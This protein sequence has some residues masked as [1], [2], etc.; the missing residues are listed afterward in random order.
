TVCK[1]S[2]SHPATAELIHIYG[3]SEGTFLA[4]QR[5]IC[6]IKPGGGYIPQAAQF[7]ALL[8]DTGKELEGPNVEGVLVF[9]RPWC[10]VVAGFWGDEEA[11]EAYWK[12]YWEHEPYSGYFYSGDV[13]RRDEDGLYTVIG[14]VDDVIKT[15]YA[16][17]IGTGEVESC[18]SMHPA[19]AEV[20]AVGC[21]H[22]IMGR[23]L[24]LFVRLFPQVSAKVT[25]AML[26]K[27]KKDFYGMLVK[28]IGELAKPS[29]IQWV[30][31]LP[32]TLSG[33]MMR[34]MLR[35][36]ADGKPKE[37]WGD[38]SGLANPEVLDVINK[39]RLEV[40]IEEDCEEDEEEEE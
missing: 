3:A 28:K 23:G 35:G 17:R 13:A 15:G 4:H 11:Q 5:D 20:A 22:P 18:I 1:H 8:D 2:D 7:P 29:L 27:F 34:R 39:G 24:Y 32:K 19:V 9:K 33:K 14:R 37:Q 30:D 31:A 26:E 25:P 40:T 16:H 21:P 12:T 10:G 36:I 38:M 6:G